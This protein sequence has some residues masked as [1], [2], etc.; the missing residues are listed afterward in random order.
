[1]AEREG[2]KGKCCR[3]LVQEWAW[4]LKMEQE[5]MG[6]L[7][8]PPERASNAGTSILFFLDTFWSCDF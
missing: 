5:G 2:E 6:S 7:L 1:M 3:T 8:E 4:T